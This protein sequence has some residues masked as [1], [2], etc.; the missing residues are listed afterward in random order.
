M[1]ARQHDDDMDDDMDDGKDIDG[2]LNSIE[3]NINKDLLKD[4]TARKRIED[5]L[6]ERKLRQQIVDYEDWD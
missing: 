2:L 5:L 6:E 1:A 4:L 3:S